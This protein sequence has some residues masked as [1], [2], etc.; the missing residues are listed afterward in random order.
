MLSKPRPQRL[1]LAIG[2]QIQDRVAFAIDQIVPW[3][4]PRRVAKSST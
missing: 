3:G 2:Q 1:G 4:W